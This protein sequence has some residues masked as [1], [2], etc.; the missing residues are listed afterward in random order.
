MDADYDPATAPKKSK[1]K[2]KKNKLAQ[3]LAAE[4][5]VYDPGILGTQS[6]VVGHVVLL[7]LLD[8]INA[9]VFIIIITVNMFQ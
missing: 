4:K 7:L 8:W 1:K 2:K 9:C 5:P 3:A 6:D